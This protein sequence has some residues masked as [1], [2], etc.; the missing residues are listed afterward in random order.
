MAEVIRLQYLRLERQGQPA[1]RITNVN[2]VSHMTDQ[3]TAL[4]LRFC[5]EKTV[6]AASNPW[7]TDLLSHKD[8]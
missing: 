1:G 5:E 3:Q 4:A 6:S 7:Y 8:K 2:R